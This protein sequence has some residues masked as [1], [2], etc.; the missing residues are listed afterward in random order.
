MTRTTTKQPVKAK[1]KLPPTLADRLKQTID[2]LN[3][4]I[5]VAET[6][7]ERRALRSRRREAFGQ[8]EAAMRLATAA[9]TPEFAAA[10]Q[11]L[12]AANREIAAAKKDLTRIAKAIE[13]AAAAAKLADRAIDLAVKVM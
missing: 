4:L 11:A 1:K 10:N 8:W 3:K 6:E 9:R 2:G 7:A 12:L 13:A 5:P